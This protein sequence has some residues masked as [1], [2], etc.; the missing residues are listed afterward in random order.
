MHMF[1][2][3]FQLWY[4]YVDFQLLILKIWE[5]IVL[6]SQKRIF[7]GSLYVNGFRF[8]AM[9]LLSIADKFILGSNT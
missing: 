9:D 8:Q 7:S 3:A 6:S 4:G 1:L 2:P 5:Y